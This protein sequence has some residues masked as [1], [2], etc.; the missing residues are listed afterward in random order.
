MTRP[1]Y[2]SVRRELWENRSIY[3]APLLVAAV[4]LFGFTISMTTLPH[5]LRGL[6]AARQRAA[7]LLPYSAIAGLVAMTAI[8][9]AVF[10]CLDARY[11][12]RRDRSILFWKSLPVSDRTT[13]LA[14]AAIP[15]VILPLLVFAI[16]VTTQAVMLLLNTAVLL[17]SG[18]NVAALWERV[19][20]FQI[21][22]AFFYA[23]IAMALWHAPLYGW[24]LMASCW[25][26]RAPFLWAVLPLLAICIF[27][28]IAFRTSHFARLLGYR[29]A[30]W[31]TEA[32]LPPVRGT[33]P[34]ALTQ[35]TPG[36]F[37]SAPGLWI[38]LVF[39]VIFFAAAVWLRRNREPL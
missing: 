17:G 26:K 31:F 14:K 36:R 29:L 34:D 21:W 4:V 7:V 6:D 15:L 38:G 37:L 13:V 10:Y 2:W 1:M 30:G 28:A 20:V 39:A 27:E 35:L 23:L 32:F 24:L 12:E 3:I 25:A 9:V 8:L 16:V 19:P 11:G 22:L 18:S 5:R 33:A